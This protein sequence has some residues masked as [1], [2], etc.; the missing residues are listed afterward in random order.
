MLSSASSACYTVTGLAQGAIIALFALGYTLVY[1]V[2]RLINFA[3]SEVF[4]LGTFAAI[5]I[6]GV[7]G[8]TEN[9]A[10]PGFGML[11]RAADRR[12]RRGDGDLRRRRGRRRADRLPAAAP[13]QRAA[14]G[15]PDHRDRCVAGDSGG[16][17][18]RVHAPQSGRRPGA[19]LAQ[20]GLPHRQDARQRHRRSC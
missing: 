16:R 20:T 5:G 3:H 11:D 7:F 8:Y 1:G 12:V 18:R 14:A 15:V 10:L 4:M 9:S 6:W 17:R 13:P 2:L 19:D